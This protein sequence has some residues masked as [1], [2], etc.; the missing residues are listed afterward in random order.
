MI[1]IPKRTKDLT[2]EKF[3]R[4]TVLGLDHLKEMKRGHR[5]LWLC[6]C[7]CGNTAL[8]A[9]DKLKSSHTKS[10]GCLKKEFLKNNP[11]RLTHGESAGGKLSTEYWRWFSMKARCYNPHNKSYPAYGG[12]GITV[13]NRWINDFAAFLADMGR[14]PPK[15]MLDRIDVNGNYEPGNCR[16][17][18]FSESVMNKRPRGIQVPIGGKTQC[19]LEW[20]KELGISYG[21][22]LRRHKKGKPLVRQKKK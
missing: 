5:F 13:C 10:C 6:G 9:S 15:Y 17:A 2:G 19:I 21:T 7:D 20:A 14:C 12:R 4:L 11:L 3:N 1:P 18:S 8:V 22:A 16:W